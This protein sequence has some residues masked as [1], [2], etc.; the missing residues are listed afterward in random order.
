[1]TKLVGPNRKSFEAHG[2][3]YRH[4][5]DQRSTEPVC[6]AIAAA[7]IGSSASEC[8]ALSTALY[9]IFRPS[10]LPVLNTPG[11]QTTLSD[12]SIKTHTNRKT[13][14]RLRR[15][16]H[17]RTLILPFPGN[18][19]QDFRIILRPVKLKSIVINIWD[20]AFFILHSPFFIQIK[21]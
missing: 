11:I 19:Y 15:N 9:L 3:R 6:G 12:V 1:M 18:K 20:E 10:W 8:E 21:K 2:R 4:L 16:S 14:Q 5:I 17:Y 13:P 7:A